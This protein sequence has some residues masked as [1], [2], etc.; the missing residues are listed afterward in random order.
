LDVPVQGRRTQGR[1]VAK[2][3]KGD[4]VV[5]VTR[6]QS[7]GDEPRGNGPGSGGGTPPAEGPED[8]GPD[9]QDTEPAATPEAHGVLP[10]DQLDLL[11]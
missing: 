9:D 7:E 4:R 10:E 11:G 8:S 5:E 6:A 3:E 1:R 2:V